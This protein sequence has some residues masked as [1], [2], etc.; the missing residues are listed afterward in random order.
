MVSW[1]FIPLPGG[2]SA[3]VLITPQDSTDPRADEMTVKAS[4][5]ESGTAGL[6]SY[7]E[8]ADCQL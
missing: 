3:R 8:G 7:S 5:P 1:C 4:L 2:G 6:C